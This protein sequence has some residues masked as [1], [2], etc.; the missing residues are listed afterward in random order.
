MV[1]QTFQAAHG[2]KGNVDLSL[3]LLTK[4]HTALQRT[5]LYLQRDQVVQESLCTSLLY[6]YGSFRLSSASKMVLHLDLHCSLN[7]VLTSHRIQAMDNGSDSHE[8]DLL[9]LHS[10]R[11][12][13]W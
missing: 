4:A 11:L 9:L 1:M 13:L 10:V 2:S 3:Q 8:L 5:K 7:Q 6:E 12:P